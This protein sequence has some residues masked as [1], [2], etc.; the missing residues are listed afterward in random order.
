MQNAKINLK[1]S[2]PSGDLNPGLPKIYRPGFLKSSFYAIFNNELLSKLHQQFR[3]YPKLILITFS[4]KKT[5]SYENAIQKRNWVCGHHTPLGK[6]R[7]KESV[8]QHSVLS[9]LL[10]FF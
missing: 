9:Y 1:N 8:L 2:R 6:I 4:A 5:P 3:N 7:L 10:S